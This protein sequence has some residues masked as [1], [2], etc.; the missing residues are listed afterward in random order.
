MSALLEIA[1]VAKS[2]GTIRAVDGIDLAVAPN[3]FFALLG[4]SGCGKTTLLRLIAGF[5]HPDRGTIRLDGA[6]ITATPPNKRPINLMFQSY[7][8]FPHMTVFANVAYGL[9]MEGL[10][11]AALKARV[12]QALGLV[13]LSDQASRKP[14]QLSGGQ[15]QRVALARAL[16][17]RPKLLLLDEPLGALD[18][19]LREKM[20]I[21]LKRL[22]QETGIAF[23]VVTHDQEE[24]LTMADRIALLDHGKVAQLGRPRDLYER[25]ESRFVADFVGQM[26]FFEGHRRGSGFAVAGLGL[27]PAQDLDA[28]PEGTAA[29]LA[30]RPERVVLS[31]TAQPGAFAAEVVGSA[32]MGQDLVVHLALAGSGLPLVARLPASHRLAA[33]IERGRQVHCSWA[34]EHARLLVK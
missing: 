31:D 32:Y 21:E 8:L 12:E 3:E 26:N 27:L 16:V 5:E 1:G 13:Q 9:E 28:V 11:G 17:K 14:H 23:L 24:A 7:A 29:S 2:F 6:D 20:Q 25:P 10:R 18:K 22:Q 30:V 19:K 33:D 4:P 15:K 34:A